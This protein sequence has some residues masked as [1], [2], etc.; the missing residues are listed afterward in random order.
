M[1]D[2]EAFAGEDKKRKD[3]IEAKNEAETLVYSAE[4]SLSEYKVR[5][6]R[7]CRVRFDVELEF[8]GLSLGRCRRFGLH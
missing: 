2:A 4:K 1:R 5:D 7:L 6:C 8:C 3:A